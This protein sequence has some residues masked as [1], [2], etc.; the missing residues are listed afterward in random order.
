M[1]FTKLKSGVNAEW[2]AVTDKGTFHINRSTTPN[3]GIVSYQVIVCFENDSMKYLADR[4][5][6]LKDAKAVAENKLKELS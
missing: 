4:L 5:Q 6:Y 2:K 3:L 1:K